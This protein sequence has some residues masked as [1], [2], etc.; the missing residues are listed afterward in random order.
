MTGIAVADN[1]KDTIDAKRPASP[2]STGGRA[3]SRSA[4]DVAGR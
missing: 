3:R 4:V 2:W 1:I